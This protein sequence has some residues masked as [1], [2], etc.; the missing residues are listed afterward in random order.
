MTDEE[1]ILDIHKAI[2]YLH[3]ISSDTKVPINMHLNPTFVAGG[4]V[5]EEAFKQGKYYPP[6]GRSSKNKQARGNNK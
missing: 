3:S 5:L 1:A 6:C 2:D 4:T